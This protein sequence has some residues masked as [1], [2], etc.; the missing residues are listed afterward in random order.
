MP[1]S[2]QKNLC[3]ERLTTASM[4]AGLQRKVLGLWSDKSI[5][6]GGKKKEPATKHYAAKAQRPDHTPYL[7]HL[8]LMSLLSTV[9]RTPEILEVPSQPVDEQVEWGERQEA[10]TFTLIRGVFQKTDAS[11]GSR[12]LILGKSLGFGYHYWTITS[13][14]GEVGQPFVLSKSVCKA[15]WQAWGFVQMA[16]FS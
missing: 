11:R 1:G 16:E 2:H 13:G 15:L 6:W 12:E 4:W 10:N 14:D 9:F 7:W 5:P 8:S 3:W